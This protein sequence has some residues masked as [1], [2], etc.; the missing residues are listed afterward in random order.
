VHRVNLQKNRLQFICRIHAATFAIDTTLGIAGQFCAERMGE[1]RIFCNPPWR[2]SPR[3]EP[4]DF[5]FIE[6]IFGC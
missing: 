2:A 1:A 3:V 4:V 6:P 5:A